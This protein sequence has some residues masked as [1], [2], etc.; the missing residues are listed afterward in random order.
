MALTSSGETLGPYRISGLLGKG[1]MDELE[2]SGETRFL[3]LEL[4][5]GETPAERLGHP[6]SIEQALRLALQIAASLFGSRQRR[7][8]S[9]SSLPTSRTPSVLHGAWHR[10][11]SDSRRVE[12]WQALDRQH[13]QSTLYPQ[14]RRARAHSRARLEKGEGVRRFSKATH[15]LRALFGI[16]PR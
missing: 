2:E 5:E 1:G 13:D 11:G 10:S 3:L 15:L 6:L 12:G 4:V 16:M 8:P 9:R 7:H 14:S